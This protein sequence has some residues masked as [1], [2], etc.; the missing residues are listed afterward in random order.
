[1]KPGTLRVTDGVE[2][3]VDQGKGKLLGSNG[4][5]GTVD[6]VTGEVQIKF[7]TPPPE[8]TEITCCYDHFD[9]VPE[10]HLISSNPLQT[11]SKGAINAEIEVDSLGFG[12]YYFC[13]LDSMNDTLVNE[14]LLCPRLT[15]SQTEADVRDLQPGRH[16]VKINGMEKIIMIHSDE[17]IYFLLSL[18]ALP[19][20]LTTLVFKKFS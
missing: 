10:I 16:V 7:K 2:E 5:S 11:N 12:Q 18:S 1:M 17:N 13:A 6:Y 15:L 3:L 14:I 4:G 9:S 20:A 8:D 19:V